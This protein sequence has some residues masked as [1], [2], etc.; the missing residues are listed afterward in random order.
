MEMNSLWRTGFGRVATRSAQILLVLTLL[1]AIVFGLTKISLVIVPV[2][3]ALILASA[4]YPVVTF[5]QKRRINRTVGSIVTI[6]GSLAVLVGAG[7]FIVTSVQTQWGKLSKSVVEGFEQIVAWLHSGDLPVSIEKIDEAIEQVTNYFTSSSFGHGA[8]Q[9][10]GDLFSVL[11][12]FVLTFVILFFFLKDGKKIYSFVLSFM[13]STFRDKALEAGERSV[14]VLGSYIRGTTT[15][16]LVD[17]LLIGIG[18]TILDVP[19]VL[20]LCLLVFI[21]AYI[22]YIGATSAGIVASLVALV[23]N[24]LQTAIIVGIIVLAVNQL[25]GHVLAP[26]ILGNALKMSPLAI[27]LIL[28]IGTLIGG[29]LGTLL[30]VPLM[31]VVWA[32]WS[33][34]HEAEVE[35]TL[36]ETKAAEEEEQSVEPAPADKDDSSAKSD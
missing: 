4:I 3:L 26:V 6:L 30:A 1:C 2:F 8:L 35:E 32:A 9:V 19:L 31:A 28:A 29:M 27:L 25:E 13:P 21:G 14:N 5:M 22:P 7:F 17:V 34:W 20:P 18:L 12:G 11:T 24:D 16:A 10:S 33:T 15:V 36:E 23:S